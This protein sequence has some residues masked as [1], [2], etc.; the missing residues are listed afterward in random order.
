ML[1]SAEH[2]ICLADKYQIL[3]ITITQLSWAWKMF[4]YL[5]TCLSICYHFCYVNGFSFLAPVS[6]LLS[7][8]MYFLY[9]I[10]ETSYLS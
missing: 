7:L 1:N 8:E 6:N 3:N 5:G 10:F 9:Y 2:E 4:Y